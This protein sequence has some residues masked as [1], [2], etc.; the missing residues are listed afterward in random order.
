MSLQESLSRE[1]P[2]DTYQVGQEMLAP[3]NIFRQIGEHFD[4]LFPEERDFAEIYQSTGRG[5]ISPL[6]L[7]IV[8]VFQI[9]EKLPDRVAAEYV[10]SRID[11]KYAMHLPLSYAGFHFTDLYAFRQRL[12]ASGWERKVFEQ[13]LEKL[14]QLGLL[15]V[16]GK[17]RTDSTHILGMVEWLSRLE[18]VLES[19]RLALR[20]ASEAAM[21]WAEENLPATFIEVYGE[22]I[23]TYGMSDEDI[24]IGW[25]RAGKDGFWFITQIDQTAPEPVQQLTEVEL[26]RQVL[27]QQFPQGPDQPPPTQRPTGKE[28]IQSPHDAQAR[29][30]VKRNKVWFGYKAQVTETCDEGSPHLVVD[31]EPQNALEQDSQALPSIQERLSER[32]LLPAELYADQAYISAALIA[33]SLRQGICLFGP[34]P[35]DTKG[36]PGFRQS[37]FVIDYAK[38][39]AICPAGQV[40][41]VWSEKSAPDGS[42]PTVKLRFNGKICQECRFFGQCTCSSQGRSLELH[43]YRNLLKFYRNLMQTDNFQLAIQLRAGVEATISE[44]TRKYGLRQARYRGEAKLRLQSAFTAAAINLN[45]VTRWWNLNTQVCYS[46]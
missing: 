45:R 44:L 13:L 17:M 46:I 42:P 18:L 4:E 28:I 11:W 23:S 7:T 21:Q 25:K 8:T 19:I 32:D 2:T 43:P 15:R 3:T 12:L 41:R 6:L 36:P 27:A 1:I 38:R 29:Q 26:L 20:A 34:C 24:A 40:S 31:L 16:R 37:D 30:G 9:M 35:L 33:D 39:Q 22:R 10:A 14:K 5:A